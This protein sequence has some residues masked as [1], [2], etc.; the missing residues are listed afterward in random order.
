MSGRAIDIGLR[1]RVACKWQ[2]GVSRRLMRAR[3]W[4]HVTRAG[5]I[6]CAGD[7]RVSFLIAEPL[8]SSVGMTLY[9][10]KGSTLYASC[11]LF[12]QNLIHVRQASCKWG[13]SACSAVSS[14]LALV[15]SA[16]EPEESLSPQDAAFTPITAAG[17]G[18]RRVTKRYVL[19]FGASRVIALPDHPPPCLSPGH[20]HAHIPGP[21]CW[22]SYMALGPKWTT[23]RTARW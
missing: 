2:V 10:A 5:V 17:R 1:W 8:R 19:L 18:V 6:V 22:Y 3:C 12:L 15:N 11:C 9:S 14:G 7:I 16:A 13:S 21:R 23:Q 4:W 20:F